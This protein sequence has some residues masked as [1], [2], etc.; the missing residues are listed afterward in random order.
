MTDV[1]MEYADIRKLS[2]SV[3]KISEEKAMEK[4]LTLNVEGSS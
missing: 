1:I 2:L 4:I 3:N